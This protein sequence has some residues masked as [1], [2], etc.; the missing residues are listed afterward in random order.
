MTAEILDFEKNNYLQHCR[1]I[2]N[3]SPNSLAAYEQD[4]DCFIRFRHEYQRDTKLNDLLVVAY[5]NYLR[6]TRRHQQST[7]RRR[8][9]TLRAYCKWLQKQQKTNDDPFVGLELDLRPP[10]RLPRPV[11]RVDVRTLLAYRRDMDRFDGARAAMGTERLRAEARTTV[12]AI[13]L[14]VST[15]VRV[16]EL[17]R[18]KLPSISN[19]GCR[20]RIQGKGNRERNVYV[21][22]PDLRAELQWIKLEASQNPH[23]GDYLLLNQH[24]R[25]LSE[26]A[27]RRRLRILSGECKLD[28]RITPH[29]F[30]HSAATFLI[31]EGVDIR[32]VQ[33]LLGH[34]SIATTEIYTRVSDNALMQAIN[35]SDPLGK[36]LSKF[37]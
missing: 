22:N 3:L 20:I 12:L 5:L 8:M 25:R 17:T 18:I 21:G 2:R 35:T 24:L 32:F 4:I 9:V 7:I 28:T 27:L 26:Q 1:G 33:R 11:D 15:G 31:E 34:S 30:R 10:K 29:R 16:G 13:K 37:T 14:M 19:D 23:D 36:L 6:E